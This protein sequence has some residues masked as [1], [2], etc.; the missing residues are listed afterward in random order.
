MDDK[1]FAL[2][3]RPR[4]EKAV[5]THLLNKGYRVFLPVYETRRA[6]SDRTKIIELPLFSGYLFCRFNP[7]LRSA[8]VV[9]TPGVL[10]IVGNGAVPEPL[11]ESEI[12]AIQRIV[13]SRL[14]SGPWPYL[15]DGARVQILAGPL[16]GMEGT[17]VELK[18]GLR[19]IV[20]VSLLQRSVAVE[21]NPGW[22]K[23]L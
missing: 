17:V 13:E 14:P 1:W 11:H 22:V 8:P 20:T 5:R 21:V 7:A 4:G 3:V 10:R 19:V 2:S 15:C 16:S 6:W 18:S 9:T 23:A 12:T